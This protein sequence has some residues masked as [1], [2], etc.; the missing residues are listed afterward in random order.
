MDGTYELF[1][2]FF[3]QPSRLGGRRGRDRCCPGRAPVHREH[4][5]RR[6]HPRRG[7]HRPRHRVVPQRPLARLQDR[8]RDRPRAAIP[9]R[10]ARDG[11]RGAGRGRVADGRARGRRRAGVGRLGGGRGPGG[12]AGDHLHARQGSGPV[13][14]GPSGSSSSTAA[15]GTITDEDG[16]W[17]KFGVAPRSIPDWL[18]PG[19]RLRRRLPRTGRVGPAVGVG[20]PG[21][22]R[23]HRRRARR[24]RPVGSDRAP[25]DTGCGQAGRTAGRPSASRPNCSRTSPRFGWTRVAARRSRLAQWRGPTEE[26]EAVCRHFRDP[27]LA[28]RA[29]AVPI[30]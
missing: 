6:R 1:R 21:P 19:G 15:S 18:G 29:A 13:R 14:G 4:A 27:A 9:V 22:L 28:E 25:V 26:F 23:Q 3:G 2:Q 10:G 30:R 11:A 8:G 16:V 20:G 7:G 17:A 24:R 5:R 12:G